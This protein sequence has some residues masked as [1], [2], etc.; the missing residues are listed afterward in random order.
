MENLTEKELNIRVADL[1]EAQRLD[2]FLSRCEA[3]LSRSTAQKLIKSGHV[4]VNAELA[5]SS[6]LVNNG[7]CI[8][9]KNMQSFLQTKIPSSLNPTRLSLEIYYEDDDLIVVNKP[10]GIAVH[11][12]NNTRSPTLVEGV[13]A[14]T[15]LSAEGQELLRP[16]VVHRLD[17]DTTGLIVFAKNLPTHAGLAKQFQEKS[18]VRVYTALLSGVPKWSEQDLTTY[19]RRHP[20]KRQSFQALDIQ[21]VKAEVLNLEKLKLASSHFRVMKTYAHCLSLVEV[22]LKTGRTHQIRVHAKFLG[23]PVFGDQIY[24][25]SHTT[26]SKLPGVIKSSLAKITRQLLHA[27][28]L[29]FIHPQSQRWL[30]FRAPLPQDFQEIVNQLEHLQE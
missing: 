10:S 12:G 24:G 2:Y 23:F 18:N 21:Q 16:G 14:H 28:C 22:T 8:Q 17:A 25:T 9:I 7:D 19:Y 30:E 26:I 20:L 11:P 3:K 6:S 4:M 13:L 5:K 1:K 27:G 29:G 15:Q